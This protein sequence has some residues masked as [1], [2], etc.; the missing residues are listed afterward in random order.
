MAQGTHSYAQEATR[1][2]KHKVPEVL[3][4]WWLG[5][6]NAVPRNPPQGAVPWYTNRFNVAKMTCIALVRVDI[7]I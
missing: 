5:Q 2:T 3:L 1:N 7:I 6:P 4:A